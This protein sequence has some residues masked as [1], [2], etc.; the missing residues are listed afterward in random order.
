MWKKL[1]YKWVQDYRQWCPA[2]PGPYWSYMA[3][4]NGGGSCSSA[5]A[6]AAA[7]VA[8]AVAADRNDDDRKNAPPV[9]EQRSTRL[10]RRQSYRRKHAAPD[11]ILY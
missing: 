11:M 8:V 5:P 3:N 9:S 2:L 6:A 7:V 10:V 1:F 4:G